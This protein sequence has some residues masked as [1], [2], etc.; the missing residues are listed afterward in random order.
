MNRKNSDRERDSYLQGRETNLG[1]LS[2]HSSNSDFF[3]TPS[4]YDSNQSMGGIGS[5]NGQVD[6][7]DFPDDDLSMCEMG[8]STTV[9]YRKQYSQ[10]NTFLHDDKIESTRSS[11]LAGQNESFSTPVQPSLTN[12]GPTGTQE[13]MSFL[14]TPRDTSFLNKSLCSIPEGVALENVESKKKIEVNVVERTSSNEATDSNQ[15]RDAG[16]AASS[17]AGDDISRTDAT[18]QTFKQPSNLPTKFETDLVRSDSQNDNYLTV[19]RKFVEKQLF[20][21]NS[22]LDMY[23]HP[24]KSSSTTTSSSKTVK[25][26]SDQPSQEYQ[27]INFTRDVQTD[28]DDN[29]KNPENGN[30]DLQMNRYHPGVKTPRNSP[31]DG[32][33]NQIISVNRTTMEI[34]TDGGQIKLPDEKISKSSENSEIQTQKLLTTPKLKKVNSIKKVTEEHEKK[35]E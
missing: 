29:L 2:K 7:D 8:I 20:E 35:L 3:P 10:D 21:N 6:P 27:P 9:N 19:K 15:P 18:H 13:S 32:E 11:N 26:H 22:F 1:H 34:L 24:P 30:Q 31:F 17:M 12:S 33:E 25:N 28:Q 16:I 23:Q 14:T 4:N 5:R